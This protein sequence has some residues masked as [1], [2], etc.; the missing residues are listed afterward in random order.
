MNSGL[1]AR[2]DGETLGS[3]ISPADKDKGKVELS[4]LCQ[5]VA[6]GEKGLN[7]HL[8]GKNHNVKAV[9][10]TTQKMGRST[11]T[12][13]SLMKSNQCVKATKVLLP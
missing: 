10:L 13:L 11:K 5:I 4:A 8:Q 9:S 6:T 7:D 3:G 12:T 2:Q 1:D